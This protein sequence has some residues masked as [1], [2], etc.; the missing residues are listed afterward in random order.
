MFRPLTPA[1]A[2][3]PQWLSGPL[4]WRGRLLRTLMW[5]LLRSPIWRRNGTWRLSN[6]PTPW[7]SRTQQNYKK[8]LVARRRL[9][10]PWRASLRFNRPA[11]GTDRGT[12]I[13]LEPMDFLVVTSA[14]T[15][16]FPA[17]RSRALARG[18]SGTTTGICGSFRRTCA[19]RMRSGRGRRNGPSR[20]SMRVSL[21]QAL[22]PFC[23]T[24]GSRHR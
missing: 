21:R 19:T 1:T 2:R 14:P 23:S 13:L 9:H 3:S 17:S 8:T 4:R 6:W 10:W 24:S 18:W 12:S 16:H 22:I 11:R 5:G 7:P 20:D 15:G